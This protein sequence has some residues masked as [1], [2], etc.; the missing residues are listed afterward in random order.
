MKLT[1]HVPGGSSGVFALVRHGLR[2]RVFLMS[3]A[4]L[5]LLVGSFWPQG[6]ELLLRLFQIA[7]VVCPFL[8][9]RWAIGSLL[10]LDRAAKQVEARMQFTLVDFLLL[11]FL[12]QM[13]M[14]LIHGLL[15][16]DP[17]G[18]RWLFDVYAWFAFGAMWLASAQRLSRA[19]IERS[20]HRA[21]FLG[22]V[23]PAAI[24]GT[25]ASPVLAVW[26]FALMAD[27]D[28]RRAGLVIAAQLTL[29]VALYVAQRLTRWLVAAGREVPGLPDP[30]AG[31]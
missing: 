14:A 29:L 3:V 5:G 11:F 27:Q 31:P 24:F 9:V 6:R 28:W 18:I 20:S 2:P 23:L 15:M 21:V 13:P 17:L 26:L 16:P 25:I 7:L 22:F 1:A 30:E 10:P 4:G 12:I 8:A 19:G